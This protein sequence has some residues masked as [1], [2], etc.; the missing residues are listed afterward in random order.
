MHVTLINRTKTRKGIFAIAGFFF[1]NAIRFSCFFFPFPSCLPPFLYYL[2]FFKHS[3][4]R[5]KFLVLIKQGTLLALVVA[6]SL[7]AQVEN[8]MV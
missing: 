1:L 6:Y 7:T 8:F 5:V 2:L 3:T 4:N